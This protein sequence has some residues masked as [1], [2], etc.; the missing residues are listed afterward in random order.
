MYL[1]IE[2]IMI[3]V[4]LKRLIFFF[5]VQIYNSVGI[6]GGPDDI[7]CARRKRHVE[8]YVCWKAQAWK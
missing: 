6:C 1:L 2:A 3:M 8:R 5:S 4:P 7:L